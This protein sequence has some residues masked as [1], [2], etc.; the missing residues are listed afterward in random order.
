MDAAKALANGMLLL[1]DADRNAATG[2]LGYDLVVNHKALSEQET[3][4]HRWDGGKW[5]PAGKGNLRVNGNGMALS[6]PR[7][8]LQQKTGDPAFDFHWADNIQ[9]FGDVS[10]LG[11]NGDSAP[12]RRANYRFDVKTR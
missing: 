6:F 11:V 3:V 4:V 7:T 2:W 10:E 5:Q 1:V 12:D 9:E 8:L